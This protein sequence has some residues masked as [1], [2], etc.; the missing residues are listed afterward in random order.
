MIP[1][2]ERSHRQADVREGQVDRVAHLPIQV[3]RPPKEVVS[4]L[5]A[6]GWLDWHILQALATTAMNDRLDREGLS[7]A[8]D[9]DAPG[10]TVQGAF[11]RIYCG[12]GK[13]N[14]CRNDLRSSL[15][16]ALDVPASQLYDENRGTPAL[17]RV[18]GCPSTSSDQWCYD[19]DK[20][21]SLGA[22][23]VPTFHWINRPT[24]QQALEVQGH[25]PR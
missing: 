14:K 25:R 6:R 12:A 5:R 17:D 4:L 16:A 9:L 24:F 3:G 11:S 21:R 22:I 18:A 23:S 2:A 20:Y 8:G 13:L 10:D 15:R 7:T 19:S 1:A